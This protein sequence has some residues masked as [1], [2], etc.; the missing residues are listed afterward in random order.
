MTAEKRALLLAEDEALARA[1]QQAGYEPVQ[2]ANPEQARERLHEEGWEL[3]L[4]TP[5]TPRVVRGLLDALPGRQRRA[6]LVIEVVE[7]PATGDR[8]AAWSRGVDFVLES[9]AC[10]DLGAHVERERAAK[11][12][13]Y[14]DFAAVMEGRER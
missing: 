1:V 6:L 2:A 13:V 8:T 11:Q 7:N 10:A 4:V 14:A 9:D 3:V 5:D 12:A